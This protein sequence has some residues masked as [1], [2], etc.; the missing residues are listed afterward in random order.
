MSAGEGVG[1]PRKLDGFG[2]VGCNLGV[3]IA[4]G[5]RQILTHVGARSAQTGWACWRDVRE[6][7]VVG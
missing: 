2:G 3:C 1:S 6:K 7:N 5:M 4:D